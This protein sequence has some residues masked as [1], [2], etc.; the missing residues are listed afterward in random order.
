LVLLEYG[1]YQCPHC[2]RAFPIV[3]RLQKALAGKL[4]FVF[5]NFPLSEVHPDALNA[6]KVAEAA[7]FQGKFWETH[8]MLFE[9]QENLDVESLAQYA[10]KLRLDV[11]VLNGAVVSSQVEE[12]ITVDFEGG[13]RSGANG[14]PTF[15]VNGIRYDGDW[16]YGPFL[17]AL[18]AV[19]GEVESD[20]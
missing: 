10:A 8:D 2:G 17:S 20:D 9:K 19:L 1:D 6:A 16:S 15:F 12:K 18:K 11:E 7:A 14:T 4:K 3:K 5:R 13:V